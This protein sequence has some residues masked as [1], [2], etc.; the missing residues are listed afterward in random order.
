MTL[1]DNSTISFLFWSGLRDYLACSLLGGIIPSQNSGYKVTRL[2][3]YCIMVL[4]CCI[5]STF[6]R[7]SLSSSRGLHSA[8]LHSAPLDP[9]TPLDVLTSPHPSSDSASGS[10]SDSDSVVLESAALSFAVSRSIPSC[11]YY[12]RD[13]L[14]PILCVPCSQRYR[15]GRDTMYCETVFCLLVMA[16]QMPSN[17]ASKEINCLPLPKN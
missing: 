15:I 3:P 10:S 14:S 13:T 9:L 7:S 16:F 12:R 11:S 6:H 5:F 17:P 8:P 2:C 1:L 4:C